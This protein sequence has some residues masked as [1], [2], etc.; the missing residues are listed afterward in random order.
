M[1]RSSSAHVLGKQH[2]VCL[3]GQDPRATCGG[4]EAIHPRRTQRAYRRHRPAVDDASREPRNYH[5]SLDAGKVRRPKLV[6][7][8]APVALLEWTYGLSDAALLTCGLPVL[9]IVGRNVSPL[10]G[11]QLCHGYGLSRPIVATVV[12]DRVPTTQRQRGRARC[13]W[14]S[15]RT[16]HG[17]TNARR[18]GQRPVQ[19]VCGNDTRVFVDASSCTWCDL[20]SRQ[21]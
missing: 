19:I 10:C 7:E 1:G 14:L 6:D 17:R 5:G 18:R 9:A 2:R 20:R 12:A 11:D 4:I 8:S 13:G 16:S 15:C 21:W 3:G